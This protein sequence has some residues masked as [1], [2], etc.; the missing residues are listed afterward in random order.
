MSQVMPFAIAAGVAVAGALLVVFVQHC[1]FRAQ[2]ARLKDGLGTGQVPSDLK[3]LKLARVAYLAMI[4]FGGLGGLLLVQQ[5]GVHALSDE[6][7]LVMGF[8]RGVASVNTE[9]D[10]KHGHPAAHARGVLAKAVTEDLTLFS[11]SENAEFSLST[12]LLVSCNVASD[13]PSGMPYQVEVGQCVP[14]R[15]VLD[16]VR[17][18]QG[19]STWYL[20]EEELYIEFEALLD[21]KKKLSRH[22]DEEKGLALIGIPIDQVHVGD[23]D[24]ELR[25]RQRRGPTS[26]DVYRRF[27]WY[28]MP[29]DFGGQHV[30]AKYQA[31]L[32]FGYPIVDKSPVVVRRQG[33]GPRADVAL[34][35]FESS[36]ALT[37][38]SIAN[39]F[40][41]SAADLSKP[42]ELHLLLRL[43]QH[44]G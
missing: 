12:S 7:A 35:S 31:T 29:E 23:F 38:K 39:G 13:Q 8:H 4:L 32:R 20:K 1:V 40:I 28:A 21:P 26:D 36:D 42:V 17:V 41:V 18:T 11:V 27:T 6:T 14:H 34:S 37:I 22:E 43:K 10:E 19:E 9:P 24:V 44:S 33:G 30:L 2:A 16:L 15:L 5:Q 25:F 3:P